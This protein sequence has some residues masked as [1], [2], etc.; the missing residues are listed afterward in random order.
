MIARVTRPVALVGMPGAGKSTVG[1]GLVSRLKGEF[2]DLD[3]GVEARAGATVAR[4]FAQR[5]EREFR[6][7]EVAELA[8]AIDSSPALIACGGGIVETVAG[9]ELLR[10][11]CRV[12]W[13]EVAPDEAALRLGA[14]AAGRPLLE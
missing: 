11:G 8:A 1:P 13:L 12:V 14:G 9:L 5:G 4:L 3:A 7:L 2:I 6:R 10:G